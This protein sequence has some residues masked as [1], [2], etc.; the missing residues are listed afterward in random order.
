MS[1]TRIKKTKST[2]KYVKNSSKQRA[3]PKTKKRK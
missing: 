2:Y 3:V 1:T